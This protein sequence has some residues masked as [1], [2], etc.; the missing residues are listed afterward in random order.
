MVARASLEVASKVTARLEHLIHY[1]DGTIVERNS[2]GNDPPA[3]GVGENFDPTVPRRVG[4]TA[5]TTHPTIS[6]WDAF[7][8]DTWELLP[9]RDRRRATILDALGVAPPE[10]IGGHVQSAFDG[11]SMR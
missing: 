11:V 9:P 3:A 6:G 2:Y 7:A 5:V 1:M 10:T 4:W 8:K